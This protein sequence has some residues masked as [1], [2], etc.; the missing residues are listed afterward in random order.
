MARPTIA[1]HGRDGVCAAPGTGA[2]EFFVRY[3]SHVAYLGE[4]VARAAEHA[5]MDDDLGRHGGGAG[6]VA[7]YQTAPFNTEGMSP[8]WIRLDDRLSVGTRVDILPLP[9]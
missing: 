2:S 9:L 5:V 4:D 3:A 6:I 8:A 1:I 7:L